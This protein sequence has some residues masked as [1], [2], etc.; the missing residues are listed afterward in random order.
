LA[1][2]SALVEGGG[3]SRDDEDAWFRENGPDTPDLLEH[4]RT[5]GTEYDLVLF[6]TF[7]YAPSFFGLPLVRDR[8]VLIP[9][10]E[11]DPIVRLRILSD[12]FS[13]PRGFMFLTPEEADLIAER[14]RGPLATSI[15]IGAGLEPVD[16]IID[17]THLSRLGIVPPY[18]L[19]LGRV[20][21]NK[22]CDTMFRHYERFV[23]RD[24]AVAPLVIAG[25]VYMPL[26]DRPWLKSLGFVEDRARSAL[27]ASARLL[28]VPSPY[29]SLS[30]ALLE[31]WNHGCPSLVNGRC[32][33]LKG[34]VVRANGGL[35]YHHVEEFIAGARELF[36][37]ADLARQLGCQGQAYVDRHYRW[38]VVMEK[39]EAFLA[40]LVKP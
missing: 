32:A 13:L 20:D 17:R 3:G 38:P 10:A 2:L 5:R 7:R 12:Y 4:L 16:G 37:N 28:I 15:V 27:L 8:A 35:Y 1:D 19:Y 26:P 25:P 9:T 24:G 30:I 40:T 21:P 11:D 33:V 6:W 22:G 23:E 18:A 36:G 34:Q 39:V 29:E 14:A 31:G